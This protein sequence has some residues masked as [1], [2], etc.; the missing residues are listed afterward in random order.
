MPV[1]LPG[2][3]VY[4]TGMSVDPTGCVEDMVTTAL[5]CGFPVESWSSEYDESAYEVNIR[6]ND[7]LPAADDAFV[8]RADPA[9][10]P[11]A[12]ASSRPSSAGRSPTAAAAGCT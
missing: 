3:R 8:F 10:S 4:G 5:A 1:S 12:T 7:A 11:S 9:R 2:H 6:Y